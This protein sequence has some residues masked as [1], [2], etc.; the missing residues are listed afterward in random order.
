MEDSSLGIWFSCLGTGFGGRRGRNLGIGLL[1]EEEEEEEESESLRIS[2]TVRRVVRSVWLSSSSS[3]LLVVWDWRKESRSSSVGVLV[4][5]FV[6]VEF[7]I[8]VTW[9]RGCRFKM[10]AVGEWE[11]LG[12]VAEESCDRPEI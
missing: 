11:T 3:L 7:S 2:S 12:R 4:S 9:R 5:I 6:M 10:V 8:F 1:E